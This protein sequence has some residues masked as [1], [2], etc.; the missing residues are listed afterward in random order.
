VDGEAS[1]ALEDLEVDLLLEGVARRQGSDFRGYARSALKHRVLGARDSESLASISML[2]D[3]V[4]RDGPSMARLLAA[5]TTN[6][7]GM[8]RDPG[9]YLTLRRQ[10]VPLLRTYPFVRIWLAGC[11]TGEEVY[12]AAIL[13]AEENLVPRVRIYATDMSESVLSR[14]KAGVYPAELFA[15][16]E[17]RYLKAGGRRALGDYAR[18]GSDGMT[19]AAS[20]REN[21]VFGQHNLATDRSF[22]EF[23][24]VMCR[25]VMI[26]FGTELRRRVHGLLHESLCRLGILGLGARESLRG[27]GFEDGYETLDAEARLYR[28]LG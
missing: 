27:S 3:R 20:L 12:S 5:L 16:Y 23:N 26:H 24:V 4:L 8:F 2:Q 13:L 6:V 7:Q 17:T 11:S 1:G 19:L 28:R 14:A 10:I 15:L 22:N 25:N 9:F 18:V 21:V